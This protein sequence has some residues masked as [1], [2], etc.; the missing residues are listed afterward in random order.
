MRR[1]R[2][3]DFLLGFQ[4]AGI[5]MVVLSKCTLWLVPN[6]DIQ[7]TEFIINLNKLS[8]DLLAWIGVVFGVVVLIGR[9]RGWNEE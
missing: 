3:G 4:F 6:L 2:L 5:I 1:H 7:M 8:V 9:I